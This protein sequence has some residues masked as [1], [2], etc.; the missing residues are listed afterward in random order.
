MLD[1]TINVFEDIY[2]YFELRKDIERNKEKQKWLFLQI[3][4]KEIHIENFFKKQVIRKIL[5]QK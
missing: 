4:G 2:A 3:K 5:S 1:R